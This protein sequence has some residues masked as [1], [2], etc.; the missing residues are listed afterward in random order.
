M[1]DQPTAARALPPHPH[2]EQ[3]P[4]DVPGAVR[5]IKAAL[6]ARIAASGRTAEHYERDWPSR[7]QPGEL[8]TTGR[9]DLGMDL[10][11]NER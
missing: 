11:R 6:R 9:R 1:A 2:W 3:T 7:F 4:A 8:N 5:Q 10:P